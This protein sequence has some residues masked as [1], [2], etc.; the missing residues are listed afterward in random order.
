MQRKLGETLLE[1]AARIRQDAAKCDFDAIKDPQGEAKRERF[2]CSIGI[3]A[4]LKAILKISD[5]ELTFSKQLKLPRILKMQPKTP[6]SNA[7]DL[8]TNQ[9]WRWRVQRTT[10]KA[11]NSKSTTLLKTSPKKSCYR[12]NRYNHQADE[13]RS[14]DAICKFCRKKGHIETVCLLKKR[15]QKEAASQPRKKRVVKCLYTSDRQ[16]ISKSVY[17]YGR[18]CKFQVDT[19]S[20]DNF[21]DQ[22]KWKELGRQSQTLN[23]LVPATSKW[24]YWE[25][26]NT[27]SRLMQ[28]VNPRR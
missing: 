2:I 18:D 3:E 24:R 27:L 8:G 25:S 1:L 13:C 28:L 19:G 4:V 9:Y 17:M 5:E 21:C 16:P 20:Q 11:A 23:T 6:K 10:R 26:S 12:C 22:T 7:T 15:K 14:K